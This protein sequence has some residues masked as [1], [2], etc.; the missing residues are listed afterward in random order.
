MTDADE[1]PGF[2]L[3]IPVLVRATFQSSSVAMVVTVPRF[4]IRGREPDPTASLHAFLRVW[5]RPAARGGG[6]TVG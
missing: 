2:G 6:I 3:H 5:V 4:A 1:D